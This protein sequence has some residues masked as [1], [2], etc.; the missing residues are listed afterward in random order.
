MAVASTVPPPSP[1]TSSASSR[2]ASSR[3]SPGDNGADTPVTI[4][5]LNDGGDLER[6]TLRDNR[7]RRSA[8]ASHDTQEGVQRVGTAAAAEK[9]Q[10]NTRRLVL[11]VTKSVG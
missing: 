3:Y 2:E 1:P 6:E 10:H 9:S 7:K 11:I 4:R 8:A 5:M